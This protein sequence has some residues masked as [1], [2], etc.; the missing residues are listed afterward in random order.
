MPAIRPIGLF[1]GSSSTGNGAASAVTVDVSVAV[2][3]RCIRIFL[4]QFTR[5]DVFRFLRGLEFFDDIDDDDGGIVLAR[6]ARI[7]Y[8]FDESV[9]TFLRGRCFAGEFDNFFVSKGIQAVT[10]EDQAIARFHFQRVFR[11]IDLGNILAGQRAHQHVPGETLFRFHRRTGLGHAVEKSTIAVVGV[12]LGQFA[13]TQQV[14]VAVTDAHPPELVAFQDTGNEGT[15]HPF[16][17]RGFCDGGGDR[18]VGLQHRLVEDVGKVVVGEIAGGM[19]IEGLHRHVARHVTGGMTTHAVR[20]DHHRAAGIPVGVTQVRD[21]KGVFLVIP[22]P[23]DLGAG[24][25]ESH[26]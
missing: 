8:T 10:G 12:F 19:A 7:L 16:E 5:G 17:R 9:D 4:L 22:R 1:F 21:E 18:A 25:I 15:A 6:R 24:D 14:E 20:H 3:P 26:Y 13:V 2:L 23:V 11:A